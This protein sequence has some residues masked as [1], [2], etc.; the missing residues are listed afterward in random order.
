MLWLSQYTTPPPPPW[1]FVGHLSIILNDFANAPWWQ[2][3]LASTLKCP[4]WG[5]RKSANAQPVGK[6][7]NCVVM[8]S[9]ENNKWPPDPDRIPNSK[10]SLDFQD[11][12]T[13]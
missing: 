1:Q 8:I 6:Y 9:D 13:M 3:G 2:G 10:D 12:E 4:W 11:Y 7:G 5:F